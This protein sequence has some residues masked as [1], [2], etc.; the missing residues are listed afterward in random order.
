M[1]VCMFEGFSSL[2]PKGTRSPETSRLSRSAAQPVASQVAAA[3]S[4]QWPSTSSALARANS[5]CCKGF[6]ELGRGTAAGRAIGGVL[7]YTCH[8]PS[9]LIWQ[10]CPRGPCGWHSCVYSN[11]CLLILGTLS[12]DADCMRQVGNETWLTPIFNPSSWFP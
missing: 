12:F 11:F 9:M 1:C 5:S 7:F 2:G 3:A 10:I 6:L 4:G 8:R